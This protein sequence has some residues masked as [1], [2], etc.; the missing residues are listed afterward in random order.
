MDWTTRQGR[1]PEWI[2]GELLRRLSQAR[3][4]GGAPIGIL[5]HHLDHD[6]RAWRTLEG[7]LRHLTVER[8]FA[9]H[10]ADDLA[11]GMQPRPQ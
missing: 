9:F 4:R 10:H 5:S 3:A 6:D 11:A 8:G 2:R 1:P 7:L